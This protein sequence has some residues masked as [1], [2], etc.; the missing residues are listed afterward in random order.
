VTTTNKKGK[1]V[2]SAPKSTQGPKKASANKTVKPAK[3][4]RLCQQPKKLV[5]P[6]QPHLSPIEEI[7]D[8]LDNLLL[9][10]CVEL[11]RR[12]LT[13]IPTLPTGPARTRVVLKI[14]V[15]LAAE[16]GSTA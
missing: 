10:A 2:K 8:L 11:T 13:S 14:V 3:T 6:Y 7:S 4:K 5:A 1:T 16:Y 15:L 9:D 12:L